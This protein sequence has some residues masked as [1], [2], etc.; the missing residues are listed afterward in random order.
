M[1][2]EEA[3][4]VVTLRQVYDSIK[5]LGMRWKKVVQIPITGNSERSLVLR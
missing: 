1:I 4:I 2:K 3:D 5:A